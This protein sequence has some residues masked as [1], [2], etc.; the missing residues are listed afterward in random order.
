[1]KNQYFDVKFS[2]ETGAI[3]KITPVGDPYEINFIKEGGSFLE[4]HSYV[5]TDFSGEEDR[6]SADYEKNGVRIN[7]RYHFEGE[8]IVCEMVLKN[9]NSFP[10]YFDGR[11]GLALSAHIND[12]YDSSEVCMTN[13]A[14]AHIFTGL[15]S[16]YINAERMGDFGKNLGIVFTKGSFS[17]YSQKDVKSNDRG[18][19]SLHVTPFVLKGGEIYEIACEI[20]THSGKEEFAEKSENYLSCLRVVSPEGFS[21]VQGE[22]VSF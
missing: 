18:Y 20:F 4:P 15:H 3:T 13:R 7:C 10:V 19:F 11:E 17:S 9:T 16:T 6:T 14:H 5:L 21:F 8:R 22:T 2:K 12:K 1:M